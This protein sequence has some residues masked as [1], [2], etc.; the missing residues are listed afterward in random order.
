MRC[1]VVAICLLQ[2]APVLEAP[3]E[4]F[5]A[6]PHNALHCKIFSHV[7]ILVGAFYLVVATHVA[8]VGFHTFARLEAV[9]MDVIEDLEVRPCA[10]GRGPLTQTKFLARMSMPSS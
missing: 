6:R 4:G 8:V 7:A 9:H 10:G 2:D 1:D 3:I 5:V